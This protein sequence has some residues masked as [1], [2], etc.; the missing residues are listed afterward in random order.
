M[1]HLTKTGLSVAAGVVA[2][3]LTGCGGSSGGGSDAKS[4]SATSNKTAASPTAS[5]VPSK[6]VPAA[7]DNTKGWSVSKPGD[8]GE[9]AYPAITAD[10]KLVL[11]RWNAADGASSRIVARDAKSGAVRWSSKPV[12]V[13]KPSGQSGGSVQTDTRVLVTHKDGKEYAI[14][15]STGVDGGDGVNNGSPVTRLDVYDVASSG[16]QVA[17]LREIT[18]P[19]L[20]TNGYSALLDGGTVLVQ[21]HQAAAT[22][23]VT[24]GEVTTYGAQSP[25][26]KPP[27]SCPMLVGDCGLNAEIV[28]QTPVGPLVQG[29]RAFWSN[30]WFSGNAV[31]AGAQANVGSGN[32]TAYGTPGGQVVAAWPTDGGDDVLWAVHDGRTGQVLASTACKKNG[33]HTVEPTFSADGR[34]LIADLAVFDLQAKQGHCFAA[35]AARKQVTVTA[36]DPDGTAYGQAGAGSQ[37]GLPTSVVLASDQAA[38]LPDGTLVPSLTG[39]GVAVFGT[40]TAGGESILVYPHR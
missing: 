3:S 25:V 19:G 16:D 24:T 5:A 21:Q 7:F 1:K 36:V 40:S 34:Y 13:P 35:T 22:T 27:A 26:L 11:L 9:L 37:D 6:P 39:A 29:F 33:S 10:S 15:A 12:A 14:L 38:P 20:A 2:L 23:D 4:A 17:P 18:V 31:P 30:G 28:G 32:V 8:G